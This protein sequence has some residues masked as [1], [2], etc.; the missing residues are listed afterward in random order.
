[1]RNTPSL[2]SRSSSRSFARCRKGSCPFER[3]QMWNVLR[4]TELSIGL[5]QQSTT[6]GYYAKRRRR[7]RRR[8][9]TN[10]KETRRRDRA[11]PS[12]TDRWCLSIASRK[13]GRRAWQ[14]SSS[15]KTSLPKQTV[16]DSRNE[17]A[18]TVCVI[19]MICSRVRHICLHEGELPQLD[20][21]NVK[22]FIAFLSRTYEE[23]CRVSTN[24][25]IR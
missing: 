12:L 14:R 3:R 16:D 2:D 23:C 13:E 22:S 1:M 25:S 10:R 24:E 7:R 21:W 9:R 4:S 19:L 11:K 20:H 15:L 5:S 17:N 18:S 6:L 8:L